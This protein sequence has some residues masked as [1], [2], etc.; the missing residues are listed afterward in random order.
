MLLFYYNQV[1]L[2]RLGRAKSLKAGPY[3]DSQ[4]ALIELQMPTDSIKW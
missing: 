4:R 2:G 1:K 3:G